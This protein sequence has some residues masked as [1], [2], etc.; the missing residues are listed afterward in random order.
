MKYFLEKSMLG[1]FKFETQ[2]SVILLAWLN[3]RKEDLS[4]NIEVENMLS[5]KIELLYKKLLQRSPNFTE[6]FF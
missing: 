3:S 6:L 5:K 4:F 2:T 1:N